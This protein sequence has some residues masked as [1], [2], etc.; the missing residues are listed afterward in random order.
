MV[1]RKPK[2]FVLYGPEAQASWLPPAM[3]D[4]DENPAALC[5]KKWQ[6]LQSPMAAPQATPQG[7][8]RLH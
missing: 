1:S 8:K 2:P 5:R 6:G 3:A 7:R 4:R